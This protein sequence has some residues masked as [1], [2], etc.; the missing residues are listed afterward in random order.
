[1]TIGQQGENLIFLI[2]QPRAGSTLLQRILG[3]HPEIHTVSEPWLMLHPLYALRATGLTMEFNAEWGRYAVE[4]FVNTLPARRADYLVGLRRMYAFL[5]G[6]ALAPSGRR[7]FLDKTPRYYFVIPELL[8]LFPKARFVILLRNPLAVLN[9]ILKTWARADWLALADFTPDLMQAPALLLQGI[10]QAG[11]TACVVQY[12]DLVTAPEVACREICRHLGIR[13]RAGMVDY[14]KAELPRWPYGDQT[15]IY[16]HTRPNT[17]QSEAWISELSY[18]P[19]WR[20]AQD[21]LAALGEETVQQLGY[22]Y[23]DLSGLLAARRPGGLP[24]RFTLSLA[25]FLSKP[26]RQRTGWERDWE[27]LHRL[28]HQTGAAAALWT[29]GRGAVRRLAASLGA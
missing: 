18:P 25:W 29:A 1:M 16:R 5:Y 27:H 22:S 7:Y 3:G 23:G 2:S 24:L 13:F 12:E 15:H 28:F 17:A 9:S 8:E 21:Y 10:Q 4:Q 14:G 19:F 20:L 26:P 11:A 6:R